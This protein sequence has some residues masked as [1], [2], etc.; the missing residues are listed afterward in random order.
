MRNA[1]QRSSLKFRISETGVQARQPLR[2]SISPL[3]DWMSATKGNGMVHKRSFYRALFAVIDY[4][5]RSIGYFIGG[6]IAAFDALARPSGRDRLDLDA[7][8]RDA[9]ADSFEI[10][11]AASRFRSW[12]ERALDHPHFTAGQFDS[13]RSMA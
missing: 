5:G 10:E 9:Y 6:A 12:L 8:R 11:G 2:V 1:A 13:G 3:T 4:L 7:L